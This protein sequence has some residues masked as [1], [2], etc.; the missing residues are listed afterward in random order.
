[1]L[2]ATESFAM[3]INVPT[4]SVIF[5]SIEKNDGQ[6]FRTLKSGEYTQMAGRAGRR[7]IDKEGNIFLFFGTPEDLPYI[8]NVKKML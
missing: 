3:G 4:K 2:F 6:K 7:G 1:M 5:F 8:E